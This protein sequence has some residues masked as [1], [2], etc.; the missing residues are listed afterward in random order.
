VFSL[1][2]RTVLRELLQPLLLLLLRQLLV[3]HHAIAASKRRTKLE[4]ESLSITESLI[5]ELHKEPG[6][7]RFGSLTASFFIF[8]VL[9]SLVVLLSLEQSWA[10]DVWRRRQRKRRS[11]LPLR[12]EI[13]FGGFFFFFF[14]VLGIVMI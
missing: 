10:G 4:I 2:R 3:L 6:T 7:W 1:L 13:L 12:F 11:W 5:S 8:C 9:C 14:P